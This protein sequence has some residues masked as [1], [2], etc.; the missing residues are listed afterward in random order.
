MYDHPSEILLHE[1]DDLAT[2][3]HRHKCP[4]LQCKIG[5]NNVTVL[6]DTGAEL[7]CISNDLFEKLSEKAKIP[8]LPVVG[9]TI[10]GATG[11]KSKPVKRQCFIKIIFED[12]IEREICFLVLPAGADTV[13]ETRSAVD[14]PTIADINALINNIENI[15]IDQRNKLMHMLINRRNV[16]S[17]KPGLVKGYQHEIKISDTSPYMQYQYTTALAD[18]PD[19]IEKLVNHTHESLGHFG[20]NKVFNF[21]HSYFYWTDMRRK[22]RNIISCCD[23]CQ[24]TKHMNVTFTGLMQ[25]NLPQKPGE[26]ICIDLYGPLVK[27]KFGM[28]YLLVLMDAF[29]KYVVVYPLRRPT[30]QA[31]LQKIIN[32]YIPSFG[33][34]LAILS[35]NGTQFKSK[36]W[37]KVLESEKIK[38]KYTSSYHPASNPVERVMREIGRICRAYCHEK[39]NTWPDMVP[40]LMTWLNMTMHDSTGFTP[41]EIQFGRKPQSEI[42]QLINWPI[43]NNQEQTVDEI[44]ISARQ[45]M[46]KRA[47]ARRTLAERSGKIIEFKVGDLVLK[48][49]HKLSSKIDKQMSKFFQLF[50]GPYR[51]HKIL[52]PN[53][54]L[55]SDC[56]TDEIKG[57]QNINNLKPYIHNKPVMGTA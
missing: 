45:R 5:A 3:R 41:Y 19:I 49:S 34:M 14:K 25:S 40:K 50:E 57:S 13:Q 37:K 28:C 54:Y 22:I 1:K 2:D 42:K 12:Q 43:E 7:S 36:Q 9:V 27:G 23:L 32:H 47:K 44:I 17:N 26:L 30:T 51:I 11:R 48:K 8:E 29:S 4:K 33:K 56:K 53:A 10:V 18:E 20:P 31:I 15:S 6:C 39:H 21:L 38:I 55:L 16:F 52:G 46:H 35:D 24:K